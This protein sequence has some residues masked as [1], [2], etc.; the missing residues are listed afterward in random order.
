MTAQPASELYEQ[1]L[2]SIVKTLPAEQVKEILQFARFVQTQT[3]ADFAFL[4]EETAEE[5]AA[6]EALWKAQ[7]A[8]TQDGLR[9]MADDIRAEI[10]A[11]K[12]TPMTFTKDGKIVPG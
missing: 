9:R 5:I 11:G 1:T 4:E 7:F 8:A 12:S 6:D 3:L 2:L 10:R